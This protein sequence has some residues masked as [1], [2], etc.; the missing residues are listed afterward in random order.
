MGK[1]LLLSSLTE[2][3]VM[4]KKGLQVDTRVDA[5]RIVEYN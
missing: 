3:Q 5:T 1:F 4:E 2:N